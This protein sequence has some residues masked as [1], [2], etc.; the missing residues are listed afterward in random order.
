MDLVIVVGSVLM[1]LGLACV[2][3]GVF[4]EIGPSRS[5]AWQTLT[6]VTVGVGLLLAGQWL[7]R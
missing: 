5:S 4:R 7:I 3:V 2:V 1:A 6:T